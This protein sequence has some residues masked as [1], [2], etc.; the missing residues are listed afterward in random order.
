LYWPYW[1]GYQLNKRLSGNGAAETA[2]L[3]GPEHSLQCL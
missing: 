1:I 2:A 3:P